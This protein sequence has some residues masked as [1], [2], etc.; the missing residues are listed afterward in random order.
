MAI[1]TAGGVYTS[2]N[3]LL[4]WQHRSIQS[5]RHAASSVCNRQ[6]PGALHVEQT[7]YSKCQRLGDGK[8]CNGTRFLGISWSPTQEDN[9]AVLERHNTAKLHFINSIWGAHKGDLERGMLKEQPTWDITHS[10]QYHVRAQVDEVKSHSIHSTISN[11]AELYDLHR[12]ESAVERL[13]FID[14]LHAD[15]KYLFHVAEREEGGV[16]GPNPMHRASKADNECLASTLLPGRS[17]PMGHL[18]QILSSGEWLR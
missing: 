2:I 12:F 3:G 13:G 9:R 10:N 5:L 1:A 11:I 6:T 16:H 18:H 8:L 7:A 4:Q 17:N 14:S 15:I